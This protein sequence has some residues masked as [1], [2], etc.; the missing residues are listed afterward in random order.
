[1]TDQKNSLILSID[2]LDDGSQNAGFETKLVPYLA[3]SNSYKSQIGLTVTKTVSAQDDANDLT[4]DNLA[5]IVKYENSVGR[6]DALSI[7][8]NANPKLGE[9]DTSLNEPDSSATELVTFIPPTG[10]EVNNALTLQILIIVLIALVMVSV[11]IVII[12]KKVL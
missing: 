4:Y 9:F 10:I 12:K 5:E 3:D 6:K 1:M 8:G 7:P 2:S 11:G